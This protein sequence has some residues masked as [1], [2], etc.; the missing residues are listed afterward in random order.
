MEELPHKNN[1]STKQGS[2]SLWVGHKAHTKIIRSISLFLLPLTQ[3]V[4]YYHLNN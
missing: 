2:Q 4:F 3:W 1:K